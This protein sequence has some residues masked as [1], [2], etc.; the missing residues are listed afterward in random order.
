MDTRKNYNTL[1]EAFLK[2]VSETNP[3]QLTTL[4]CDYATAVG[5][6]SLKVYDLEDR[7]AASELVLRFG[8]PYLSSIYERDAIYQINGSKLD[9]IPVFDYIDHN[10]DIIIE[11]MLNKPKLFAKHYY[12][13]ADAFDAIYETK[14]CDWKLKYIENEN[15]KALATHFIQSFRLDDVNEKTGFNEETVPYQVSILNIF[16]RES[17]WG[18]YFNECFD[19]RDNQTAAN[20]VA[21]FGLEKVYLVSKYCRFVNQGWSSEFVQSLQEEDFPDAYDHFEFPLTYN[22]TTQSPMV[23]SDML[24]QPDKYCEHWYAIAEGLR[25]TLGVRMADWGCFE[26]YEVYNE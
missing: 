9:R 1:I 15:M 5:D 21:R 16:A 11:Q 23:V 17:G 26:D 25:A 7:K 18:D 8:L 6:E 19:L 12:L 22:L 3:N 14:D 2:T 20:F 4:I 24:T 13:L 10:S